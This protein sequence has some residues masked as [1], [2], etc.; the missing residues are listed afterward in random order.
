MFHNVIWQHMQG[1]VGFLITSLLQ[2]Y[3]GILQW[4][5]PENQSCFDRIMAMSL[6]PLFLAHPVGRL[7]PAAVCTSID[8]R[9][10]QETSASEDAEYLPQVN[11]EMTTIHRRGQSQ[12]NHRFH[13]LHWA[14][15]VPKLASDRIHCQVTTVNS[16]SCQNKC[17]SNRHV[18]SSGRKYNNKRKY[19]TNSKHTLS[20]TGT[21]KVQHNSKLQ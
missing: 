16:I 3:Q 1:V 17:R 14:V 10:R 15:C 21:H 8:K 2:I 13:S 18:Y 9:M 12:A 7:N 20:H 4:K 11:L 19:I 6:C 5:K